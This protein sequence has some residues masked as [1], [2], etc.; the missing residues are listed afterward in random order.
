MLALHSM[1]AMIP[2]QQTNTLKM[3]IIATVEKP[4]KRKAISK[5]TKSIGS[6]Q[7]KQQMTHKK[8]EKDKTKSKRK[9]FLCKMTL[10]R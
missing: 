6:L 5:I 7:V 3:S 10:H 2:E 1:E 4:T 9:M 8:K